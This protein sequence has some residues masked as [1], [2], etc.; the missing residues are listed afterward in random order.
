MRRVF[1]F[2]IVFAL[3][4]F[5]LTACS[6]EGDKVSKTGLSP[7]PEKVKVAPVGEKVGLLNKIKASGKIEPDVEALISSPLDAQV[8]VLHVSVEERVKK[9][10]LIVELHGVEGATPGA[11]PLNGFLRYVTS[12]I[13]GRVVELF[14]EEGERLR[15]GDELL[16]IKNMRSVKVALKIPVL[17]FD[18]LKTGQNVRVSVPGLPGL[19]FL[20]SVYSVTPIEDD[21]A[22]TFEVQTMIRNPQGKLKAG[23]KANAVIDTG[24]TKDVFVVPNSALVERGARMV[25]YIIVDDQAVEKEVKI[26]RKVGGQTHILEGL[27]PADKLVVDGAAKLIDDAQVIVIE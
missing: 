25:V 3:A 22:T 26:L 8:S 9:G 16:R 20:G 27:D 15:E 17:H 7:I 6:G 21:L 2:H 10:E 11:A 13:D 19:R 18:D 5:T 14:V 23:L 12:P 4:L 1:F 24:A